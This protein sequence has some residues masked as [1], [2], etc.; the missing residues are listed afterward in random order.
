[1]CTI[2]CIP[3]VYESITPNSGF[4]HVAWLILCEQ[5][6]CRRLI[7]PLMR[8]DYESVM[9]NSGFSQGTQVNFVQSREVQTINLSLG[10]RGWNRR[11]GMRHVIRMT[12]GRGCPGI[13]WNTVRTINISRYPLQFVRCWYI[14]LGALTLFFFWYPD[15]WPGSWSSVCLPVFR[16]PDFIFFKWGC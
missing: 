1:M 10:A 8:V 11:L 15:W 16:N 14:S 9:P 5:G 3:G 7:Y 4:S 6:K 13:I 2:T 12:L